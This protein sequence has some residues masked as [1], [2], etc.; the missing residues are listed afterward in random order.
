MRL[1]KDSQ[2]APNAVAAL[3]SATIISGVKTH[4]RHPS[5]IARA[6]RSLIEEYGERAARVSGQ[7][8]QVY[9]ANSEAQAIEVVLAMADQL[10]EPRDRGGHVHG[11]DQHMLT[12]SM[13]AAAWYAAEYINRLSALVV[14]LVRLAMNDFLSPI[15]LGEFG[16]A[17][18]C[19]AD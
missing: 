11:G 3:L 12:E 2:S 19:S 15:F 14:Q 13:A 4:L 6:N 18:H 16:K 10:A 17:S 1:Q 9:Q 8:Y 5:K 7:L